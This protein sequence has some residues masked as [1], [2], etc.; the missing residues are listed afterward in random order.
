MKI[1][2]YSS[3]DKAIKIVDKSRVLLNSPYNFKDITDSLINISHKAQKRTINLIENYG[4]FLALYNFFYSLDLSKPF[5]GKWLAKFV[6]KEMSIYLKLL[7]KNRV[8]KPMRMLKIIYYLVKRKM[9]SIEELKLRAEYLYQNRTIPNI[10]S[11]RGKA[12]I[13]CFSKTSTNLYSWDVHGD[14]HK[15]ICIE[16]EENRHFFKEVQY[17]TKEEEMDIYYATAKVLAYNFL[18]Q[19]LTYHEK[20][21]ADVMLRPFFIKNISYKPEDEIRCLLSDTESEKI[22]YAVEGQNTFLKMKITRVFIGCK[23]PNS[24]ELLDFLKLCDSRN[25]PIS[26]MTFDPT[27]KGLKPITNSP[28]N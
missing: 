22:G 17:S 11:L 16:F 19:D 2:K 15:G 27:N 26:Y 9:P 8:Y 13:S 21:F 12:R 18:E 28:E 7:N 3:L 1:Y 5:R 20:D 6:K 24:Q 25:I 10:R 4:M 14:G 23:T